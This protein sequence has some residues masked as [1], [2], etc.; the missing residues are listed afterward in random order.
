MMNWYKLAQSQILWH[1]SNNKFRKFD[2]YQTAQGI[3]WFSKDKEDLIE[4]LHG[5]SVTNE[6]PKD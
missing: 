5:A 3:V 6:L 1:I 4:N 2:L